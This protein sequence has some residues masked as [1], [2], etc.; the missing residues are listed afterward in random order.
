MPTFLVFKGGKEIKRIQGADPKSLE[1]AVKAAVS[2]VSSFSTGG[3]KLG[4]APVAAAASAGGRALGEKPTY[5]R[6][7]QAVSGFVDER[8]SR[9]AYADHC[10][11]FP[12]PLASRASWMPHMSSL[13]CI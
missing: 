2:D 12:L 5:L 9:R 1:N 3:R 10:L 6:N 11:G 13:A 4:D 7:G 8:T